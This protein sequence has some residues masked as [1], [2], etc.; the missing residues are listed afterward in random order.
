MLLYNVLLKAIIAL[1]E[2]FFAFITD[3]LNCCCFV[4]TPF[5]PCRLHYVVCIIRAKYDVK[6]V[7]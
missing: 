6:C 7:R 1:V 3:L 4:V 2:V 5:M